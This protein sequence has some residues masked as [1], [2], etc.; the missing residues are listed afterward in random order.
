[1]PVRAEVEKGNLVAHHVSFISLSL[2]ALWLSDC[3]WY[4]RD[5]M[6]N[7]LGAGHNDDQNKDQP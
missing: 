3:L 2:A 4:G 1:M 6:H 7:F 5:L